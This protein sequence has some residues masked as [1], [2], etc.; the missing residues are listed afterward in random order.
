MTGTKPR[1][2]H[3]LR[4]PN[5][6]LARAWN[7][8][9]AGRPAEMSFPPL[10]IRVTPFGYAAS[11]G[12]TTLFPSGPNFRF[13]RHATDARL[14]EASLS[15]AGTDIDLRYVKATDYDWIGEWQATKLGEWGLRFWFLLCLSADDGSEWRHDEATNIAIVT[16]GPRTVAIASAQAPLLVTGHDDIAALA[17]E[18]ETNGYWYLESR[19]CT[20]PLLALRFNFDETPS[21]RFAVAIADRE[22]LACER[23]RALLAAPTPEPV[24]PA[25]QGEAVGA[26]DAVRDV[27]GWNAVWDHVN[28]RPYVTCSRNWDLKKF[29]GFGFWLN[30]TAVNA[31]MLALFDPG[32]ARENV[33]TLLLGSTP[34]GNLPC[35]L[36]GNDAWIDRTQSPVVSLIVWQIFLRTR[37]RSLLEQAFPLL[38]R[39]QDW[40]QRS[41]DGNKNGM[42]EFGSS[43]VGKGLYLGTKLA[44][45]DESFMDNSPIHDEARWMPESRTLDC[46][47]VGLNCLVCV[48]AEIL[49]FM[50]AELGDKDAAERYGAIAT[51]MRTQIGTHFWDETR[52]IFASRLWSGDFVRSLAPTSFY[53]LGA[54]AV[55]GAQTAAL[56]R[57]LDDPKTFGGRFGLPSVSRDDPAYKDNV[58]W[59]GRIWPILN[60]LVWQGLRRAGHRDAASR[61]AE[62]GFAMFEAEWREKRL[63]PENYNADSG[64]GLDQPDTDGFYSWSALLPYMASAEI[65]D[66]SAFGG[67]EIVNAAGDATIGPVGTPAGPM[68]LERRDGVVTLRRGAHAL[69]ASNI[70]GRLHGI[71]WSAD[72]LRLTLPDNRPEGGWI[73]IAHREDVKGRAPALAL[74]QQSGHA[75]TAK[76]AGDMVEI[77]I[78]A[79]T[80]DNDLVLLLKRT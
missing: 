69:F 19:A 6:P 31:L 66:V 12:K 14:V 70:P 47:D 58:Y 25:Q 79:G 71:D 52:Q 38:A 33:A 26:I 39:N 28:H 13:G 40:W 65:M 30:D 59:R 29:G 8:W 17:A 80:G 4:T 62:R 22:D 36:T 72:R 1:S 5:V 24:L 60:W 44:A 64:A 49:S 43:P 11:A 35:L 68:T 27:M 9:G 20:G 53:P 73:R 18:Y 34:A 32:Q 16:I 51:R 76:A 42:L 55:M 57:N 61:L 74:A 78:R 63:C 48:D 41:R 56:L 10:G 75:L 67:W 15:H 77:A 21:G 23:A 54:G 2:R 37:D 46:E 7:T 45:K 3:S 50:A